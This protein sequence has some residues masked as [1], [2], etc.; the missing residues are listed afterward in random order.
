ML[1]SLALIAV[2]MQAGFAPGAGIPVSTGPS[3]RITSPLGRSGTPGSIRIVA[4]I[5]PQGGVELGPVQ[6]FIDGRLFGT[7]T[8]GAPYAV[9]WTDENPFEPREIAVAVTDALGREVRD[10]VM[11]E[12]FEIVDESQITSVLVE[13][14]VQDK[15]GRFVKTLPPSGFTLFEDGVPQV[16]DLARHE[17]VGATFALLID[18]SG[19]MSRRLDF[20]Q[21]T[22]A[23][24]AE[25]MTPLDR[26]IVAPFSKGLLST[27]G[28]TDDKRTVAEAIAAIR[29][30]GG[31][32]I[33]DSLLQLSRSFGDQPGRRAII[34]ITDGYDE[35][36]TTTVDEVLAALKTAGATVY[37]VGIGGVAGISLKGEKVLRR[38]ATE[39][40]GRVFLPSSEA[41][42]ELI[43][44]ALANDVQNRYLLT[45][46]PTN[47]KQDGTW[48]DILV[49][50]ADASYRVAARPGYFAPKPPPIRPS[51]EFTALDPEGEYRDVSADDV[52]IVEDGVP[53]K[54]ETFHEASQPVSIVLALDAS[55]SMRHREAEVIASAR[56]FAGALRPQDQ[57][58]VMLFSDSVSLV[59]DLSTNR[60]ATRE[61]IDA[62]KTAGGTALYDAVADAL[63][64][65]R[66]TEGRRVV[67]VMTDGRDENNPGTAPGST[68]TMAD[69]L[70]QLQESGV[71]IFSLGLGTKVDVEPLQ[72]FADL[73]GGRLLL[74]QDVAQLAGEFQRVVEDLRRRYV[75]GYT[76]TN[77]ERNGAW[78]KVD[79]RLR[80]APQITIRSAGGYSAP[81]R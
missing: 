1:T 78:R 33:L 63:A 76:S 19:S 81:E 20:V 22:A 35:N 30:S 74:P 21:R 34:L 47:Q 31:T 57:L 25:Y 8:D 12:P 24:L 52:E 11:L 10:R 3:L 23:L 68:H 62:Y 38:L 49:K 29:S 65:L 27:T 17:S 6:F 7:D 18:S 5:E 2:V 46:T 69:V 56:A 72:K 77:G 73:S 60:E 28:P 53:Q 16:L 41:Q 4:Q 64:R 39:T 9:E 43:H 36:S 26:T 32:A 61:A 40:G 37:A 67:V 15:N 13:A 79:I 54:V 51:I 45:Y 70:G 71:T 59:H 80:S 58:A 42:L 55:G 50:V 14:S 66:Q 75:I 48:R 44:T